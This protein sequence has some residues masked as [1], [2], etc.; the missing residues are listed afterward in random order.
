LSEECAQDSQDRREAD[1]DSPH[2]KPESSIHLQPEI[3]K[4]SIHIRAEIIDSR[5]D[6][7]NPTIQLSKCVAQSQLL[8]SIALLLSRDHVVL[9]PSSRA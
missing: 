2:Q 8:I 3:F 7:I 1:G 9:H 4:A 6:V 5:V